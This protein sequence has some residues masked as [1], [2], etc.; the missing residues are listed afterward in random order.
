VR[1]ESYKRFGYDP[2]GVFSS[3]QDEFGFAPGYGYEILVKAA[4]LA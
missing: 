3:N 4:R 1:A 2:D